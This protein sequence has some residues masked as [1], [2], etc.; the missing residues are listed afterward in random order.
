MLIEETECPI[1]L[2]NFKDTIQD[3]PWNSDIPT[4]CRHTLCLHCYENIYHSNDHQ[5]YLGNSQ[6]QAQN[7]SDTESDGYLNATEMCKA[8]GKLYADYTRLES[9]KEY[10]NELSS[11]MGIPIL[12]LIEIKKGGSSKFQGTWIHPHVAIHLAQWLSPKFAVAV[13][14]WVF[15]FMCGDLT[16]I[17]EIKQNNE[18]M[19]NQLKETQQQLEQKEQLLIETKQQIIESDDD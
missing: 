3:G 9:T 17:D 16:L 15:R 19:K 12:K 10:L 8:N 1:C 6:N 7:K 2:T 5:P 18:V 13:S 4:T 14:K 11:D